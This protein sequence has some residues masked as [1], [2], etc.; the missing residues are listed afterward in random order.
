[1]GGC[2]VPAFDDRGAAFPLGCARLGCGLQPRQMLASQMRCAAH[3]A[4][5]LAENPLEGW[6]HLTRDEVGRLI[7]GFLRRHA[8][9][10]EPSP[11]ALWNRAGLHVMP[12]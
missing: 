10:E 3:G 12:P 7:R 4:A 8:L 9:D 6:A 2:S 11:Q 1:M 5:L